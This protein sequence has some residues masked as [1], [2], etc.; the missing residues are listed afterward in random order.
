MINII[1]KDK[2]NVIICIDLKEYHVSI[3]RV[4][5]IFGGIKAKIQDINGDIVG[6][7]KTGL[8]QWIVS[9]KVS[10]YLIVINNSIAVKMQIQFNRNNDQVKYSIQDKNRNISNTNYVSKLESRSYKISDKDDTYMMIS[11]GKTPNEMRI[12]Y[13][14]NEP[15]VTS[16]IA[17]VI[18][19]AMRFQPSLDD[20]PS[21]LD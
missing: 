19:Y 17:I 21:T 20:S 10:N 6:S 18:D 16:L 7:I 4:S 8:S 13:G 14:K 11:P 2:Y 12:D 15:L 3:S 9:S 1:F 5:A